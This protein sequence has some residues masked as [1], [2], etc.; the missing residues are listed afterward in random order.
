M[1]AASRKGELRTELKTA[2]GARTEWLLRLDSNPSLLLTLRPQVRNM[3]FGHYPLMDG[4]PNA[5]PDDI[6]KRR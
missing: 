1:F 4:P 5:R 3:L 2:R 6:S